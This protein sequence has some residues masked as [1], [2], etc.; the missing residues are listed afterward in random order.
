[1]ISIT[2]ALLLLGL[3]FL[4]FFILR[5]RKSTKNDG[6]LPPHPPLTPFL[7][8]LPLIAKMT[9]KE[10]MIRNV[11]RTLSSD[12]GNIFRLKL[13]SQWLLVVTGFEYVKEINSHEYSWNRVKDWETIRF[14]YFGHND[15]KNQNKGITL[16]NSEDILPQFKEQ[17]KYVLKVLKE[18]GFGK[19]SAEDLVLIE[20]L[21]LNEEIRKFAERDEQTFCPDELFSMA[22]LNVVWSIISSETFEYG[23]ERI[24]KILHFNEVSMLFGRLITGKPL[25][26][27]PWLR[28]FPP[29]RAQFLEA[30][31]AWGGMRD[32]M[33]E[34]I[35]QHQD[36]LDEE[37]PRDFIDKYLIAA[38]DNPALSVESLLFCCID[39]FSGG[40]DTTSK[41][42]L[43]AVA[44]MINHPDIQDKVKSELRTIDKDVVSMDD[45]EVLPYTEATLN[46]IFRFSSVA[47]IPPPRQLSAPVQLGPYKIPANTI[48][49]T[50]TY[51]VH[52][53]Q[54]YWGDPEVFR[55]ERFI[56]DGKFKANE[57]ILPFG[58]GKRRCIGESLARVQNF[59]FFANLM[60]KFRFS[61]VDDDLPDL[62]P[63]PGFFIGPPSYKARI[64]CE[65]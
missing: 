12:L 7:G 20:C 44:L 36:T 16:S 42:M 37:H 58:V 47:P 39:I 55:P 3:I 53:D 6:N 61:A 18:L 56:V 32:F 62:T 10:P 13:G 38:Q 19:K 22:A 48:F 65:S 60:K 45:K 59:L 21:K 25:G 4:S 54:E 1:M 5:F 35:K 33:D 15:L 31:D 57:R 51:S 29:F 11:F 27:F 8:N 26:A 14:I 52:F 34:L 30:C 49:V 9:N 46:E 50:S 43:Y 24:R 63:V 23:D 28:Y 64:E 41:S 2:A 40:T 17:R